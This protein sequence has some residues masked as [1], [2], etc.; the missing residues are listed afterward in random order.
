MRLKPTASS[1]MYSTSETTDSHSTPAEQSGEARWAVRVLLWLPLGPLPPPHPLGLSLAVP[2]RTV[3]DALRGS[4]DHQQHGFE[5]RA[6]HFLG[7]H[8]TS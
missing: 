1:T 5:L 4:P 6:L 3:E 8:S 2:S 7:R